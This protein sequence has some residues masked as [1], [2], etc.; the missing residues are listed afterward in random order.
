MYMIY[1]VW[2]LPVKTL[3]NYL[4]YSLLCQMENKI[5]YE[6]AKVAQIVLSL[7]M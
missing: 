3:H 1:N 7:N 2:C 6:C 5:E 4:V